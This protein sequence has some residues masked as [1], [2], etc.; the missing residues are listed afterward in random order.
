MTF[1][2]FLL[3]NDQLK[4]EG[5]EKLIS[6]LIWKIKFS[7]QRKW[8]ILVKNVSIVNCSVNSALNASFLKF[9]IFSK[10]NSFFLCLLAFFD[11]FPNVGWLHFIFSKR[12]LKCIV[13]G[14]KLSIISM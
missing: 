12:F 1:A 9:E 14:A 6:F 8:V 13:S 11:S 10:N 5:H 7:S 4:C 3:I 2:L